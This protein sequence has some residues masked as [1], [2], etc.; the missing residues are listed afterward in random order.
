MVSSRE[1]SGICLI[2]AGFVGHH[3]A[4]NTAGTKI[5]DR[6]YPHD[7]DSNSEL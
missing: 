2:V 1:T 7:E 5:L 6:P 3:A 4:K